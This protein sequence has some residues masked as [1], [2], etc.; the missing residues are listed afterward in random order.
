MARAIHD[1]GRMAAI[2]LP[3]VLLGLTDTVCLAADV[4]DTASPRTESVKDADRPVFTGSLYLWAAALEGTTSTLSSLPPAKIDLSFGD[5][6]ENLDGGIMGAA[7]M[8][9]GQ[10]RVLGDMMFT[11][12]SPGGTLQG[13]SGA[14]VEL[15]TRS[16]TLQGDVLYHFYGSEALDLDAGA[17]LRFWYLH[18]K[19]SIDSGLVPGDI[20]SSDSEAWADPVLAGR[21]RGR[22]GGSWDVTL[23]GDIGG[24]GVGSQLTWQVI[25]TLDYQ[26]T[27]NLAL[28]LGYRALSV[29]YEDGDVLYDV[30]MQGPIIGATYRF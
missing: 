16:F 13:P 25:G 11:E 19:L 3:A 28:R 23:V 15:R 9:A 24:F 12:V 8:R 14:D 10:W 5:V 27:E 29:D 20:T 7:E 1:A 17:G 6:L 18:N 26:C 22:L 2:L 30:R 4:A 21:I